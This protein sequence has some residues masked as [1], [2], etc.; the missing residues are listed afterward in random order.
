MVDVGVIVEKI[1]AD[2]EGVVALS[3]GR[4][5]WTVAIEWGREAPDSPMVGAASYGMGATAGEAL[6][7]AVSDAGWA[8]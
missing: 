1:A 8:T 3:Y 7:A 4:G 6:A 5:L 2:G